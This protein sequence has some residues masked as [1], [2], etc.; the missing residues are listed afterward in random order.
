VW[1]VFLR[2][3]KETANPRQGAQLSSQ[4]DTSI[5]EVDQAASQS[6]QQSTQ[7]QR[8]AQI[9]AQLARQLDQ[10]LVDFRRSDRIQS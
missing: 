10:L 8:N 5:G 9:L 3:P 4:I 7:V 1:F 2:F 6:F